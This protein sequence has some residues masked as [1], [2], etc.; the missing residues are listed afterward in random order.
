MEEHHEWTVNTVQY[1][2]TTATTIQ[3]CQLP[4]SKY[5]ISHSFQ[6]LSKCV[7]VLLLFNYNFFVGRNRN[8]SQ[9]TVFTMSL[10]CKDVYDTDLLHTENRQCHAMYVLVQSGG[11]WSYVTAVN[12]DKTELDTLCKFCLHQQNQEGILQILSGD[13]ISACGMVSQVDL[14]E[15]RNNL[16]F[17][18]M[19]TETQ[20]SYK[21]H[22]QFLG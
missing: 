8:I 2:Q 14:N 16:Q 11:K 13:P 18:W 5:D 3:N 9:I 21:L 17:L 22:Q 10:Y 4:S 15:I 12:E 20:V 6:Y 7:F 1:N 19:F